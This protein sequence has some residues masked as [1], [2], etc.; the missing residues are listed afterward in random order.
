MISLAFDS[1]EEKLDN[2]FKQLKRNNECRDDQKRRQPRR[3]DDDSQNQ[4]VYQQLISTQKKLEDEID[5]KCRTSTQQFFYILKTLEAQDKASTGLLKTIRESQE[6]INRRLGSIE[7]KTQSKAQETTSKELSKTIQQLQEVI[8]GKL[9]GIEGELQAI[10]ARSA[11]RGRLQSSGR[12]KLESGIDEPLSPITVF[13]WDTSKELDVNQSDM[14]NES[15]MLQQSYNTSGTIPNT[16][17]ATKHGSPTPVDQLMDQGEVDAKMSTARSSSTSPFSESQRAEMWNDTLPHSYSLSDE[18]SEDITKEHF[19][20]F[21]NLLDSEETL[22]SDQVLGAS[23]NPAGLE[24]ETLDT[25]KTKDSPE[26]REDDHFIPPKLLTRERPSIS[27]Q[28]GARTRRM[29]A[30]LGPSSGSLSS[31]GGIPIKQKHKGSKAGLSRAS[32][33]DGATQDKKILSSFARKHPAAMKD[34][35]DAIKSNTDSVES[36]P[37][38]ASQPPVWRRSKRQLSHISD[39]EADNGKEKPDSSLEAIYPESS[40]L[41]T[42]ASNQPRTPEKDA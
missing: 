16:T 37:L 2:H 20:S 30:L 11:V 12:D 40:R 25:A 13:S 35:S 34:T 23:G 7:G 6:L 4:K 39:D 21:G 19:R 15:K 38:A 10:A 22:A 24:T 28:Y 41:E 31:N 3:L 29:M 8:N 14:A 42:V 1:L 17:P 32:R 9:G 27:A 26:P 18:N 33:L 36:P 5:S